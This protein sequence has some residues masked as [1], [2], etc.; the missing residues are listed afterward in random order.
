MTRC[1]R[2]IPS[3]SRLSVLS[4]GCTLFL[5]TGCGIGTLAPTTPI[6]TAGPGITGYVHGGQQPVAGAHVYLYGVSASG[7]NGTSL[8]LLGHEGTGTSLSGVVYANPAGYGTDGNGNTYVISG[9]DG[10]FT[11]NGGIPP[12]LLPSTYVCDEE[13][14]VYALAIG[15]DAGDGANSSIAL[16]ADMGP[17]MG[18]SLSSSLQVTVNEVTTAAMATALAG[19]MTGPTSVSYDSTTLGATGITNASANVAQLVDLATGAALTTTPTGSGIAPGANLNTL[20]NILAACVNSNGSH[21]TGSNCGTLFN[22]ATSTG[23]ANNGTVPSDTVT[24]MVNIAH[25]PAANVAA[26]YGLSTPTPAF[27]NAL[28]TQ[29]N[30]FTLAIAYPGSAGLNS[31][32]IPAVDAAGNVWFA[33]TQPIPAL[34]GLYTVSEVS[35][36]GVASKAFVYNHPTTQVALDP[37]GSPIWL[38][39]S[40]GGVVGRL[41]GTTFQT[42]EYNN[43]TT[44]DGHQIA[45]DP[46][47]NVF[48]SDFTAN[49]IFKLT[50]AGAAA[51]NLLSSDPGSNEPYDNIA[52]LSASDVIT[53]SNHGGLEVDKDSNLAYDGGFSDARVAFPFSLAIDGSS[54][55]WALVDG[56]LN[57]ASQASLFANSYT[58]GGL[59]TAASATQ[60]APWLA[61]DGGNNIWVANYATSTLTEFSNSGT[62]LSPSTGLYG[63]AATCPGQGLAIDGAGDIWVSCD[64][65]T[66]PI[67]EYIGLATP[68]AT[69]LQPGNFGTKP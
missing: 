8:S 27:Q 21:S 62:A 53:I 3:C 29:P 12:F 6:A 24:A 38:A 10:S 61:I 60:P 1:T 16:M 37:S 22:N 41:S 17:C 58:G 44:D 5:L 69:P 7:N 31:P 18:N 40:S 46:T 51:A 33:S 39:S 63:S 55:L 35:P 56:A 36:L 59:N 15:G 52:M 32:G 28:A 11:F 67:L 42:F 47:G 23:I 48:I 14:L 65:S 45:V 64:S 68:V 34:A 43:N 20:A 19:Y 49:N 54:N 25:H 4:L 66:A 30:D 13:Q 57:Q 9:A 50:S 2:L 26:L